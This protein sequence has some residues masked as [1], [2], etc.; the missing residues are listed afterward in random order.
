MNIYD[1]IKETE[2]KLS[3]IKCAKCGKIAYVPYIP[4]K[5]QILLGVYSYTCYV[6][7]YLHYDYGW[8]TLKNIQHSHLCPRCYKGEVEFDIFD[9][10]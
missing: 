10:K 8:H 3:H 7:S 5:D 6:N 4:S 2:Y 1:K 9:K